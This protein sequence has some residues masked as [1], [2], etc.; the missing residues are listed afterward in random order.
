MTQWE[1]S[2]LPNTKTLNTQISSWVNLTLVPFYHFPEQ[3]KL[4]Q[5]Y[6]TKAALKAI[7]SRNHSTRM[8][9]C[10]DIVCLS[11]LHHAIFRPGSFCQWAT[12]TLRTKLFAFWSQSSPPQR[13]IIEEKL[14]V[15][16]SLCHSKGTWRNLMPLP[17][18]SR[19][20]W[21][22]A[23]QISGHVESF[24]SC[25]FTDSPTGF[26]WTEH[27]EGCLNL[28]LHFSNTAKSPWL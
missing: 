3:R 12:S 27:L 15:L 28:L 17:C 25:T 26:S 2:Y 16:L 20:K 9:S 14:R 21:Y 6:K 1:K 19:K 22:G 11:G 7:L 5:V 8:L 4:V 24:W 18:C 23:E 13:P 10:G